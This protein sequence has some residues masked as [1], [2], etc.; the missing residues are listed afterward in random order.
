MILLSSS[1]GLI[2]NNIGETSPVVIDH[3]FGEIDGGENGSA[4]LA[5]LKTGF[6]GGGNCVRI[7]DNLFENSIW[8]WYGN[9]DI[10]KG[11]YHNFIDAD[12]PPTPPWGG[13]EGS[14]NDYIYP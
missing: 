11:V 9:Y 1:A 12:G 5:Y 3:N 10:I 14:G 2:G 4:Y 8:R 6:P 13:G 7:T